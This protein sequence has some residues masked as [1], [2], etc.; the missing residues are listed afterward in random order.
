MRSKNVEGGK[1]GRHFVERKLTIF[2]LRFVMTSNDSRDVITS[3]AA[4]NANQVSKA[5]L[6]TNGKTSEQNK[7]RWALGKQTLCRRCLSV[8]KNAT[9]NIKYR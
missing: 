6:E 9:S 7:Y 8:R 2:P 1:L 3:S 4:A 5:A